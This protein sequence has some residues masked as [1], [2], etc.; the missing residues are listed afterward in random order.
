MSIT[1]AKLVSWI[2][3][4]LVVGPFAGAVLTRSKRGYGVWRN[5]LLGLVGSL[6]GGTVFSLL[7]IDF[8]LS[9]VVVSLSDVV[10]AFLGAVIF[11]GVF[12]LVRALNRTRENA[13]GAVSDSADAA[14]RRR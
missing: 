12:T 6:I 8:G 4:G 13:V 11:V 7:R 10:R 9:A 5:I 3:I 1:L 2:V 14:S